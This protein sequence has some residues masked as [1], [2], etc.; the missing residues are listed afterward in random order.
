[1]R[2]EGPKIVPLPS[3]EVT[4]YIVENT[5]VHN[6]HNGLSGL[7]ESGLRSGNFLKMGEMVSTFM[8]LNCVGGPKSFIKAV[9]WENIAQTMSAEE[10]YMQVSVV[11]FLGKIHHF[12]FR[13]KKS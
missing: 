10:P 12:I 11:T 8:S 5:I 7:F 2:D 6:I 1:M 13:T 4:G 9:Y 3:P